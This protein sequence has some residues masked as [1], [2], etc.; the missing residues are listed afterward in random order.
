[1]KHTH[2]LILII[3]A[4]LAM[5]ACGAPA[6]PTLAAADVQNTALAAAFTVVAQT[7]AALPTHTAIP[8]TETPA[9]TDTPML[10]AT[11]TPLALPS[12]AASVTATS[13]Q[14]GGNSDP[15]N[16]PLKSS[17]VGRS[18]RIKIENQTGAPVTA[19]LYLNLTLLGECGYRG[20]NIGKGGATTI[21]D[22]VQGCYN[23]SVFVNDPNK[24]TKSFGY[25]CINNP[26]QWT[27]VIK[28]ENVT[29]Q[30]R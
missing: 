19:S 29:L 5:G 11:E 30:G 6:A 16:A 15:C 13:V 22:L 18:T 10:F 26:D 7:Q 23:V 28:R 3:L 20:Y 17:P 9:P 14:S 24:P 12:Q 27:F 4:A 8:P 2:T 25:G 21:T 1:M